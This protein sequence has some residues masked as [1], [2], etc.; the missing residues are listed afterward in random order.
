MNSESFR[1]YKATRQGVIPLIGLYSESGCGKTM[2]ALLLAR[3]LV[4]P[5]GDIHMIDTESR[6]G[7]LYADVIPG[8]YSV[9]DLDPPFSPERHIQALQAIIDAGAKIGVIDSC[10]MEWDSIGGVLDMAAECEEKS[11][12]KGLHNWKKPKME[13]A[14][15]IQFLLRSP[16]PL[17]LC[18]RAKR[19]T[20]QIKN[21]GKTEIVKEEFATAIQAED[22]LF[23]L[24]AHAEILPN[25]HI[26]LTKCSHPAL[27][28]CFPMDR[29]IEIQDGAKIAQWCAAAGAPAKPATT[30][31]ASNKSRLWKLTEK[32]HCGD[33]KALEAYL[34]KNDYIEAGMALSSLDEQLMGAICTQLEKESA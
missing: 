23:E 10:S 25:H 20:R 31:A 5:S 6:R 27:R 21:N 16:I 4:G 29:P 11:K 3:G 2:S 34:L 22:F 18:L 19:K 30:K 12:S 32:I 1:I 33:P 28:E 15:F 7:S 14:L 13:H 26:N 17:V 9:L 8:G 24:T